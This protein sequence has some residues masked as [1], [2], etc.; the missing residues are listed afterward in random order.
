MAIGSCSKIAAGLTYTCTTG[1]FIG[2]VVSR[3]YMANYDDIA[4]YTQDATSK[5]IDT[6]VMESTKKFY[7]FVGKPGE[8][9]S[10]T[11]DSPDS[12]NNYAPWTVTFTGVFYPDTT[13]DR[14]KLDAVKDG[15]GY[16][17]VIER[18]AGYMECLGIDVASGTVSDPQGA[19]MWAG[20]KG[21]SG[22]LKTDDVAFTINLKGT[23][24]H[25]PKKFLPTGGTLAAAITY[26]EGLAT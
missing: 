17:L 14:E 24:S 13:L 16:V 8:A 6:L 20:G 25:I 18:Y 22:V 12:G 2:G 26:M 5:V 4:S 21:G 1:M 23:S 10:V 9:H 19:L 7:R 11:F 3:V 15:G